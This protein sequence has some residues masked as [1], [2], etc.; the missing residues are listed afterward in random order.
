MLVLKRKTGEKIQIG[1][2]ITITVCGCGEGGVRLGVEAPDDLPVFRREIF[3]H[4]TASPVVEASTTL[5]RLCRDLIGRLRP[6]AA[7]FGCDCT[8]NW[9]RERE[10]ELQEIEQRGAA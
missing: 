2:R 8:L 5:G 1:E 7:R 6:L 10:A 3:D 9:L 4:R